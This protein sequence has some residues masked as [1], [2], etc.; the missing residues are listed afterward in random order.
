L[1]RRIDELRPFSYQAD[2]Q[3]VLRRN[4]HPA[5]GDRQWPLE[6][7]TANL[8]WA[9]EIQGLLDCVFLHGVRQ[10]LWRW[11]LHDRC[12]HPAE[13]NSGQGQ[14]NALYVTFRVR[15][16]SASSSSSSLWR[17]A[18]PGYSS[19]RPAPRGSFPRTGPGAV[20]RPLPGTP[21]R[22]VRA[23]HPAAA[24]NWSKRP[25]CAG[26][27]CAGPPEAA[28]P[29]VLSSRGRPP[30]P[31]TARAALR[32]RV[33]D[34]GPPGPVSANGAG[35]RC[36]VSART[37]EGERGS[38]WPGAVYDGGVAL[39]ASEIPSTRGPGQSRIQCGVD[40]GGG[41]SPAVGASFVGENQR[42]QRVGVRPSH[43]PVSARV[44]LAQRASDQNAKGNVEC[45]GLVPVGCSALRDA[46]TCREGT[47]QLLTSSGREN[48]SE[49]AL[50]LL[51]TRIQWR[52]KKVAEKKKKKSVIFYIKK[53]QHHFFVAIFK[54]HSCAGRFITGI[55][56][57][58]SS[59]IIMRLAQYGPS[60][61]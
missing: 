53:S 49:E 17:G 14:G 54:N 34:A 38:G 46:D 50:D 43:D 10:E 19:G 2:G 60:P 57:Y 51:R 31:A 7:G 12:W 8:P 26:R 47:P 44:R 33:R 24:R 40:S 41:A 42:A 20:G 23:T 11:L 15:S 21:G 6:P 56:C 1:A 27:G 29:A 30:P 58:M 55:Y 61:S 45:P 37:P 52:K 3:R 13:H 39:S 36:R 48:T 16:W 32:A 5:Q 4:A 35:G 28:G 22:H 25:G 18:R 9:Q 59:Y